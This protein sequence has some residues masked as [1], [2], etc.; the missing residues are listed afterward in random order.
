MTTTTAYQLPAVKTRSAIARLFPLRLA[1]IEQLMFLDDRPRHPM[2]FFGQLEFSGR[3]SLPALEA[4]LASSLVRHPLLHACVARVRGRWCWI[5]SP[6]ST[7]AIDVDQLDVPVTA[8][9]TPSI[10]LR[11]QP[12]VRL[13]VRQSE[14]RSKLVLEFHH[15]CC[16]GQG[17][18]RFVEDL[19]ML[20]AGEMCTAD[21][22]PALDKLDN[23]LLH[24]RAHFRPAASL[25]G[26]SKARL[27]RQLADAWGFHT[28]SP[29]VLASPHDKPG[30]SV[31]N[32]DLPGTV[33]HVFDAE[34]SAAIRQLVGQGSGTINDVA[35]SLLFTTLAD[36]NRLYMPG[37]D[38]GWLRILMPADLRDR[39]DLRMPAANRMS[40]CFVARRMSACRDWRSLLGGVQRETLHIKRTRLGLDFLNIVAALQKLPGMM[41]A[42]MLLPRVLATAVL[43]N[44]ADPMKRMR[45]KFATDHGRLVIGNLLLESV[46]GSPP[47]RPGTRAGFGIGAYADRIIVNAKCDP[48]LFTAADTRRLL[49]RYVQAWLDWLAN[50]SAGNSLEGRLRMP[51]AGQRLF[52]GQVP[53]G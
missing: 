12:G 53:P 49:E 16:D 26:S 32:D 1:P 3:I 8:S 15:A 6:E 51:T 39:G 29:Q 14:Q 25:P 45:G 30:R 40:P 47:L 4:A 18:M 7:P 35:M 28:C 31:L 22:R 9:R 23:Y 34:Q 52:S 19:L 24:R 21:E 11:S 17:G 10:D 2:T 36:W 38:N 44:M 27:P 5:R 42:L 37:E 33:T 46:T 20:Y 50:E 13:W 43:T 48:R 41:P